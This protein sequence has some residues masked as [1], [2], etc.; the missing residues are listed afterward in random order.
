M[1]FLPLAI[2]AV[3]F[4]VMCL[5]DEHFMIKQDIDKKIIERT[6]EQA[7]KMWLA[8]VLLFLILGIISM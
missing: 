5:W 6:I 4:F 7:M 3:G 1:D 8:G 2:W